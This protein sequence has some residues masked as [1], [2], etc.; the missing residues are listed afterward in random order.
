M[1]FMGSLSYDTQRSVTALELDCLVQLFI[2]FKQ[3]Q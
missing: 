1:Q 2:L 3:I